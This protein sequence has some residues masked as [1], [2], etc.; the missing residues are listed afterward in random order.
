MYPASVLGIAIAFDGM[1][2]DE[3]TCGPVSKLTPFLRTWANSDEAVI[4]WLLLLHIESRKARPMSVMPPVITM[5][6]IS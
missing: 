6:A 5:K 4:Q 1:S 2:P 3:Y